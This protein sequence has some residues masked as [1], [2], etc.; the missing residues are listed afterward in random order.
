MYVSEKENIK[1]I[2]NEK[3][4]T[5]ILHEFF[6]DFMKTPQVSSLEESIR[7]MELLIDELS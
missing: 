4:F 3:S 2:L 6:R 7:Y 1:F 5:K